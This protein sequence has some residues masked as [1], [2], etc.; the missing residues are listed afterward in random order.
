[1]TKDT[2]TLSKE[3][4]MRISSVALLF[5][6]EIDWFIEWS[7]YP[8]FPLHAIK[9]MR[10]PKYLQSEAYDVFTKICK[11][12]I[13]IP[14]LSEDRR[15]ILRKFRTT[16]R[17]G[18]PLVSYL[19]QEEI[20]A[21]PTI[22]TERVTLTDGNGLRL[23]ISTA[24][25]WTWS[26]MYHLRKGLNQHIFLGEY[27]KMSLEDARAIKRKARLMIMERKEPIEYLKSQAHKKLR[28]ILRETRISVPLSPAVGEVTTATWR[29]M[30]LQQDQRLQNQQEEIARELAQFV[31]Y[32]L[33]HLPENTQL[34]QLLDEVI[35]KHR[36]PTEV[37]PL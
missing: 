23:D 26:Y 19:T 3:S 13:I 25:R 33:A 32:W 37:P 15:K 28:D 14:P 9:T 30:I 7:E 22:P 20:D 8:D 5:G 6:I 11:K 17:Y 10:G 34:L 31:S 1:M 29:G 16:A 12:E 21:L 4:L 18:G 27:P 2:N 24:G 35:I 36:W